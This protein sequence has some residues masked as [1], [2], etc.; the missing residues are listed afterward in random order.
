MAAVLRL[1]SH[2]ETY[3]DG[4][5][6][7]REGAPG[8][9]MFVILSGRIRVTRSLGQLGEE[10][11]A[12]L[13]TGEC[14]GEMGLVD[15]AP[16]SGRARAMGE[17]TLLIIDRSG[18]DRLEGRLA[19]KVMGNLA[20]ILSGRLRHA[21]EQLTRLATL[22]R[23]QAGRIRSMTEKHPDRLSGADLSGAELGGTDLHGAD[24]RCATLTSALLREARL[25][26]ADLRGA[27][28]RGAHLADCDLRNAD[29]RGA[30]LTG[31]SFKECNFHEARIDGGQ[32]LQEEE[33]DLGVRPAEADD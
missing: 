23:E 3:K 24:L 31:A 8:H 9:Q 27:D 10:E 6:V 33:T 25:S 17:T 1:G 16:R 13:D 20:V 28:L 30:D 26:K 22:G 4:A 15:P 12:I 5:V 32:R 11:L 14:V 7:F 2:R 18:I 29:L 19:A 21:N